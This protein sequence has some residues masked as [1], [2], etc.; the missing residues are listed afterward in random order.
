[1]NI[2]MIIAENLKRIRKEKNLSMGQVAEKAGISKVILSQL[3]KGEKNNPTINTIW[4]IAGAL[5]VP[6]TMLLDKPEDSTKLVTFEEAM[7]NVSRSEDDKCKIYCYYSSDYKHN[8]EFFKM[9]IE[10]EG[11]YLSPGHTSKGEEYIFVEKGKLILTLEE[12]SFILK[13]G[14][15]LHFNS[16]KPHE[17]KNLCESRTEMIVA[18]FYVR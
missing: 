11:V 4:K 16:D 8:V 14:D 3:E 15:S 9:H 18:N 17:Y 5:N 13:E 6:Y 10:P 7:E 1:M 2:G 12:K